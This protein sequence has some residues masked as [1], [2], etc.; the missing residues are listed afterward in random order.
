M[1]TTLIIFTGFGIKNMNQPEHDF[2]SIKEFAWKM[3]VHPNTI[4]RSIKSGRVQGFKI[5]A[6]KRGTYRIP[7]AEINRIALLDMEAMIERIIEQ[8]K[9]LGN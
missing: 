9:S 6:G 7:A 3:G 2:Y 1:I 8:R 5:G 4:R